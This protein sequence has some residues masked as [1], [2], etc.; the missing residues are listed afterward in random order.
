LTCDEE[1]DL[2]EEDNFW[3]IPDEIMLDDNDPSNDDGDLDAPI[4]TSIVQPGLVVFNFKRVT[5]SATILKAQKQPYTGRGGLF[6][7]PT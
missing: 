4:N 5:T 6:T 7:T 1:E 2:D 3:A